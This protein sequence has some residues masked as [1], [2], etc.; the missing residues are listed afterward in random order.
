MSKH[1]RRSRSGVTWSS[2][3]RFPGIL[4]TLA[5]A[6]YLAWN[7]RWLAAAAVPPSILLGIFGIPAPTTGM[8]RSTLA[9]LN[10]DWGEAFLWNPFTIL[11]HLILAW[12]AVEITSTLLRRQRLALSKPLAVTWPVML[13]AAWITKLA[14][15]SQWW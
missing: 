7:I 13:L 4:G 12:T 8:T 14:M 9:F 6:F 5:F 1:A 3:V 2:V 10:G 15:G 11:F